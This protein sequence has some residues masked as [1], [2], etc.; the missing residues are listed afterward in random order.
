MINFGFAILYVLFTEKACILENMLR[1]SRGTDWPSD[2]LKLE[3]WLDISK[4]MT[5]QLTLSVT[6]HKFQKIK[7]KTTEIEIHNTGKFKVSMGPL[8]CID[9][10]IFKGFQLPPIAI[11]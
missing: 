5:K 2:I 1:F 9:G 7:I 8:K 6:I 10:Y 3:K 11:K 4:F